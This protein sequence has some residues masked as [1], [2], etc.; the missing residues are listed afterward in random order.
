MKWFSFV[1]YFQLASKTAELSK[2]CEK[3]FKLEQELAFYKLDAK[4]EHL[5]TLPPP[6]GL[7]VDKPFKNDKKST[8]TKNRLI[9]MKSSIMLDNLTGCFSCFFFEK[10][11]G[12]DRCNLISE[13]ILNMVKTFSI[14][15]INKALYEL[16]IFRWR[17]QS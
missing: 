4:F 6:D 5:G 16:G 3:Q 14:I 2:A 17:V 13:A 1:I 9:L 12:Q 11:T 10:F 15:I 8:T 7:E